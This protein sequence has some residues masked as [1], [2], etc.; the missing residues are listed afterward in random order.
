M[1]ES[2]EVFPESNKTRLDEV[3]DNMRGA[4]GSG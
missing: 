4:F 3:L 1:A 2:W